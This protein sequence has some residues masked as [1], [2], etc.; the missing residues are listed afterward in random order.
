M[1]VRAAEFRSVL[2]GARFVPVPRQ[3]QPEDL[4]GPAWGSILT[5]SCAKEAVH[6]LVGPLIWRKN[7]WHVQILNF[8]FDP[9]ASLSDYKEMAD[10][11]V[12][13]LGLDAQSSR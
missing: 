8:F 9:K 5:F 13:S 1:V 11:A 3:V 4:K 10:D 2:K 6:R 7:R 12:K